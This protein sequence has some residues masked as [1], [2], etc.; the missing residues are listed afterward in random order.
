M[1][2]YM[3]VSV[4]TMKKREQFNH[5]GINF[6]WDILAL[7]SKNLKCS[8]YITQIIL[9]RIFNRLSLENKN[10]EIC[11]VDCLN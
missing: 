1:N 7:I 9:V 8:L 4:T 6:Q 11:K 3:N 5:L 2:T 10:D